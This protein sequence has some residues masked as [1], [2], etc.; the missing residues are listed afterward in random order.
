MIPNPF[1]CRVAPRHLAPRRP[2]PHSP[3]QQGQWRGRGRSRQASW[4]LT[5]YWVL[6]LMVVTRLRVGV[7]VCVDDRRDMIDTPEVMPTTR[8]C[9]HDY[10]SV[11]NGE[12]GG[13]LG[14]SLPTWLAF[15]PAHPSQQRIA[16]KAP[17]SM[18]VY[19]TSSSDNHA[20]SFYQFYCYY[21]ILVLSKQ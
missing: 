16:T 15:H 12:G 5:R 1:A 11:V 3:Q 19:C 4:L 6:M 10:R 17:S 21:F 18:G 8:R 2:A 9:I 20:S 14:L 13:S 7:A